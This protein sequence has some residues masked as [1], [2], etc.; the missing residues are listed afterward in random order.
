MTNL[1]FHVYDSANN[2]V[3]HNLNVKELE[4]NI[5]DKKIDL[6]KHEVVPVWEEPT[7]DIEPSY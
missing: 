1:T 6:T 5:Q 7:Q 3:K 2:V 4:D